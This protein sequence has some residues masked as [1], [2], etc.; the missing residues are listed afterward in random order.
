MKSLF[1]T[2]ACAAMLAVFAS[3]EKDLEPYSE[4][5]C[6]LNFWY[7]NW[8][9]EVAMTDDIG[10]H[11]YSTYNQSDYSFYYEGQPERSRPSHRPKANY[12]G[13]DGEC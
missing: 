1:Y 8:D 6:R 11:M 7:L 10:D 13:Y 5:Q 4:E 9:N 2:L 3:C 12:A